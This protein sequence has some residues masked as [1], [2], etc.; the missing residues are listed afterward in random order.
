MADIHY[1]KVYFASLFSVFI[2]FAILIVMR[3]PLHFL[4]EEIFVYTISIL[5]LIPTVLL[6][7]RKK[8]VKLKV[9]VAYIPAIIGF[10]VSLLSNNSVY[11]LMSFPIFLLNFLVILPRRRDE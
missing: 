8:S 2:L 4:L 10:S 5:G 7:I 11:F 3:V 9:A 6:F 1:R